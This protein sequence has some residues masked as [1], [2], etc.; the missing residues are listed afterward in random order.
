[1]TSR[2]PLLAAA[3]AAL[4]LIVMVV[5]WAGM[6]SRAPESPPAVDQADAA[7]GD[8]LATLQIPEFEMV[9]QSGAARSR[10]IFT[11]RWTILAFTFV[12][13]TTICPI[14]HSHLI[15]LQSMLQ[16]T[17]VK[18]VT[19]SVDPVHDTP[20]AM[21]AYAERISADPSVWTFLTG[22]AGA[23]ERILAGL[24]FSADP[25]PAQAITLPDG[26]TMNNI[27]HPSK[28]LLIGPDGRVRAMET[29]LEWSG[30]LTL[31][32]RAKVLAQQERG[33]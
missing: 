16:G 7:E 9:D 8:P 26:K 19:I 5:S 27:L 14:M 20:E 18:I 4:L 1:M 31:L 10:E 15:R 32:E 24:R 11:G 6:R 29:G 17:P 3:L 33:K 30:P 12:N 28:V 2:F 23:I 25:D 21:R 22:D 13:C